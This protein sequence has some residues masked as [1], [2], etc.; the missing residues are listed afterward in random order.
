M[1]NNIK[2]AF[3][4]L[5]QTIGVT[6]IAQK[7]PNVQ[8][9]SLRA[10]ANVKV[11]GKTTE[12]D[13]TFQAYNHATDIF[14]T[15]SNDDDHLYL[16]VQA[17]DPQIVN[18]II[19]GGIT[20][21]IQKTGKKNDK[22][23]ISITYP[24]FDKANRPYLRGGGVSK[25]QSFSSGGGSGETRTMVMDAK[26]AGGAP[27]KMEG[28]SAMNANNKRL[29]DNSKFI[30]VVGIKDLDTMISVYNADGIKTAELFN[31][32]MAYTY[33]L[34][35]DLKKLGLTVNEITKFAYHVTLNPY[36][37]FDGA[38]VKVIT[39]DGSA[40]SPQASAATQELMTKLAAM[41]G[42]G[43][44]GSPTDFWGEYTLA[45]K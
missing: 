17:T 21:T 34:S 4:F 33:E 20:F 44:G 41:N 9:A 24:I 35:I 28:D 12:W 19:G 42:G 8:S 16:T 27:A 45:K 1:R 25:I 18:K 38:N 31:T 29:A 2:I 5:L 14:Y 36:N 23:G 40:P 10:P 30:K 43:A 6:T 32:K 3:T 7:L 11:D 26:P 22:D 37:M 13:N 15:I 39:R